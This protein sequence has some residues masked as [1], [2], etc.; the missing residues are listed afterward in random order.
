VD[1]QAKIELLKKS[2]FAFDL[3]L[4][5]DE[6][7][8]TR[9]LGPNGLGDRL[10]HEMIATGADF[11]VL[12]VVD[13]QYNAA[14]EVLCFTVEGSEHQCRLDYDQPFVADLQTAVRQVLDGVNGALRR[15]TI[16][17]RYIC[18]RDSCTG[19][20]CTYRLM[21]LPTP[22]LGELEAELNIVCGVSPEDYEVRRSSLSA[23]VPVAK[24]ANV[25]MSERGRQNLGGGS[26][27]A[28]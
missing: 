28:R 2:A 13:H 10:L 4:T 21:V 11:F 3:D 22:W 5:L 14:G 24:L 25:D 18:V 8:W 6:I 20:G 12:E 23:D 26:L 16:P 9:I 17:F 19:A 7:E 15:Q 1:K 27:E